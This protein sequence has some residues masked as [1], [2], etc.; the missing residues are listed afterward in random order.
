M[1]L[2]PEN[3][4]AE[5]D[6]TTENLQL[7]QQKKKTRK[8]TTLSSESFENIRNKYVKNVGAEMA[9]GVMMVN[10]LKFASENPVIV[11]VHPKGIQWTVG[12]SSGRVRV[13]DLNIERP[14]EDAYH[15]FEHAI[16]EPP[17][18]QEKH[19]VTDIRYFHEKVRNT[20]AVKVPT[21]AKIVVTH[22]S[23]HI[24]VIEYRCRNPC[25]FKIL[26]EVQEESSGI[27]LN[28]KFNSI[29]TTSISYDNERIITGGSDCNIRVYDNTLDLLLICRKSDIADV[30]DGHAMRVLAILY[31]PLGATKPE[32]QHTFI[33]GGWDDTIMIWDDR[34]TTSVFQYHGPHVCSNDG[35]DVDYG[36]NTILTANWSRDKP[37]YHIYRFNSF[38]VTETQFETHDLEKE[39]SSPITSYIPDP[40]NQVNC[41]A[42]V[43]RWL[44][45]DILLLAGGNDPLILVLYKD[46][47]EVITCITELEN[48]IIAA[49]FRKRSKGGIHLCAC[50]GEVLLSIAFDKSAVTRKVKN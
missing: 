5:N 38:V 4:E 7:K 33:S 16:F 8:I 19:C 50:M 10:E 31:H 20:K 12:Y 37:L 27:D 15:E 23:G 49:D 40:H 39:F 17:S 2:S 29:L 47:S 44:S 48:A 42:Y 22:A 46:R 35:L 32:Y 21:N 11:R 13:F 1:I 24:R 45:S 36:N 41:M 14:H 9:P 18:T 3:G 6:S 25:I 34:K 26:C 43:G 28:E 30:M